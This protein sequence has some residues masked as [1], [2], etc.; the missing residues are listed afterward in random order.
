MAMLMV[1][2]TLGPVERAVFVLREVFATPHAEIAEA[3]GKTP[4]AVR[5]VAQRAREHVGARRPR[6]KVSRAE[7]QAAV[8][9]FK[10]ALVTGDVAGLLEVL[11]PDVVLVAD[12]GGLVAAVRHPV[13]GAD[14][15]AR[16]LSGFARIVPNAGAGTVWL[17]GEPAVRID[18]DGELDTAVSVIVEGGRVARIYAHRNPQ[19]LTRLEEETPLTRARDDLG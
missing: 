10:A 4:A 6:M 18:L 17:N 5:Q 13:V 7:Q 15:V 12:G 14:Q 9:R 1:L 3:V 16:L 2:E 19:K 11:A 8:E